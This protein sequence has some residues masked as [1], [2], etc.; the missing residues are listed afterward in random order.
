MSTKKVVK[1]KI[2]IVRSFRLL[3][4]HVYDQS[5]KKEDSD[6]GS[7]EERKYSNVDNNMFVIQMFGI[8]EKGKTCCLYVNDYQPFFFVKIHDDWSQYK[9]NSVVRYLKENVPNRYENSLVSFKVVEH[10]KLYGFSGGKKHKFI[11][12]IFFGAPIDLKAR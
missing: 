5:E 8:D 6:S 7:D 4:F 10:S 9:I 11:K 1:R 3:D 12:L 2:S